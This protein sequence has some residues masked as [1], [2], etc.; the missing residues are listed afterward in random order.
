MVRL[1]LELG[2]LI[3]LR[4]TPWCPIQPSTPTSTA[5]FLRGSSRVRNTN[6]ILG[7]VVR[8]L[9]VSSSSTIDILTG[10]RTIILRVIHSRRH[11]IL[12]ISI[13]QVRQR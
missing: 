11:N 3:L 6:S 10:W 5:I 7:L 2:V 8:R 4:N 12:R 13:L 9:A 1:L